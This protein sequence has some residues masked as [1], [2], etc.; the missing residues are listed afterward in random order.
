M[1]VQLN[2]VRIFNGA[3]DHGIIIY[4]QKRKL[5]K[6]ISILLRYKGYLKQCPFYF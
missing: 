1:D 2:F 5:E 6:T 4:V 3:T